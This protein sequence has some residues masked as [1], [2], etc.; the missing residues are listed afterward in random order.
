MERIVPWQLVESQ[1]RLPWKLF[2]GG[3]NVLEHDGAAL[4]REVKAVAARQA[5]NSSQMRDFRTSHPPLPKHMPSVYLYNPHSTLRAP[6]DG[7]TRTY[8]G[9]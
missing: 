4:F 7:A 5:E 3:Q 9:F 6:E 2:N 8:V 1:R